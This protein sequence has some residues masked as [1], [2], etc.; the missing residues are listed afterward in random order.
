VASVLVIDD[1]RSV[2][3]LFKQIFKDTDVRQLT[4]NTA[5]EGL[6]LLADEKPDVVVLD[7]ML[8]DQ[9]GLETFVSVA[10]VAS[11]AGW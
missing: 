9:S 10:S 2:L 8:P 6:K 3:H 7:I 5:A 4:A 11:W 1:D